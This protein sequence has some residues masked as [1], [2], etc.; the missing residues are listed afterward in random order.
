[1]P[2]NESLMYVL[3]KEHETKSLKDIIGLSPAA[4]EGISDEKAKQLQQALGAKTIKDLANSKYVK[5][6]QALVALAE[7]EKTPK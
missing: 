5:R 7:A 1:M 4:L 6:A 3:D 2:T